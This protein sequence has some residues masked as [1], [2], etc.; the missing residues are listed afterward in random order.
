MKKIFNLSKST[1]FTNNIDALKDSWEAN[2][3]QVMLKRPDPNEDSLLSSIQAEVFSRK[4]TERDGHSIED[5]RFD[6]YNVHNENTFRAECLNGE[7]IHIQVNTLSGIREDKVEWTDFAWYYYQDK[8]LEVVVSRI[9]PDFDKEA[10]WDES[11][12]IRYYSVMP[13]VY[14]G[15]EDHN[16]YVLPDF[17]SFDTN[18]RGFLEA[19]HP[20]FELDFRNNVF[21]IEDC[22]V[23]TYAG[24][25]SRQVLTVRNVGIDVYCYWIAD[26]SNTWMWRRIIPRE[27]RRTT[28]ETWRETN[29]PKSTLAQFEQ[30]TG[31]DSVD[32]SLAEWTRTFLKVMCNDTCKEEDLVGLLRFPGAVER[33]FEEKFLTRDELR[34]KVRSCMSTGK[35]N[36]IDYR[37]KPEGKPFINMKDGYV[38]TIMP[39]NHDR[40]W[41]TQVDYKKEVSLDELVDPDTPLKKYHFQNRAVI[42]V[43]VPNDQ[44][45]RLSFV[46]FDKMDEQGFPVTL[47]TLKEGKFYDKESGWSGPTVEEE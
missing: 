20:G 43:Q 35:Y 38:Y 30:A 44:Y 32:P 10:G 7:V 46:D 6:L 45:Y 16:L 2:F 23:F 31:I 40:R 22:L 8:V 39:D 26:S 15:Y 18:I 4:L 27:S 17:Y 28:F 36:C 47:N 42:R 24:D 25:I 13:G 9:S 21:Q 29:F 11:E 3:T 19:F 12:F 1:L 34:D 37:I 33:L 41:Y 5:K 14:V